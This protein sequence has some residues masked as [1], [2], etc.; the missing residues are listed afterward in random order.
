M[1]RFTPRDG[2]QVL[3]RGRVE[4][5]RGARR[6]PAH[7]RLH[8]GSRRR[9]AAAALRGA[10]A[11]ARRRRPVRRR[12]QA[13]RCRACRGGSASS[14]R[15][16]ARRCA[17]CCTSCAGA[18]ARFPCCSTRCQVQGAARGGA[19][20]SD[21][22]ARVGARRMR[23][24]DPGARRRLARRPVGVQ[25]R[26]V[27]RAIDDCARSRSSPASA[28]RSI[29][30]SPISS[31]TCARRRRRA[32]PSWS[33]RTAA[34]GCAMSCASRDRLTVGAAARA[35]DSAAIALRGCSG[36]SQ[37]LHPGVEL[38]QRAQRL[39]ELEQRLIRVVRAGISD[40][41]SAERCC[42]SQRSCVSTRPR[43][44]SRMRAAL[45]QLR[46][47]SMRDALARTAWKQLRRAHWPSRRERSTPSVRSRRSSVATRS[48]PMRRALWSRT[49][50]TFDAGEIIDARLSQGS[51]RARVER[52]HE[53]G[54]GLRLPRDR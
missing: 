29:S 8:G 11:Q 33:C 45:G 47:R 41:D 7:R 54:A 34:S 31:P 17:T 4:P 18:S 43:C 50:R 1:A 42:S 24:A 26:S 20:R 27:A 30:R 48:S 28:T 38:R 10:E 49:P 23:R 2:M 40:R 12:A 21:D 53:S 16:P 22:P 15:R 6:L 25:R 5:V 3:V 52:S 44:A 51:I 32:R 36:G 9:R 14:P 39:D 19:D 46:E 35:Q 13:R 37:Q